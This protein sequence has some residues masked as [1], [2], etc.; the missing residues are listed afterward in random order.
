MFSMQDRQVQLAA[1]RDDEHVG[2][3]GLVDAQR[4]V[5][6][7]LALQALADLAAGDVLAFACRRAAR[8]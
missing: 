8:C 7:Q 3:A 5:A 1:A 4:D 6:Q 2:V